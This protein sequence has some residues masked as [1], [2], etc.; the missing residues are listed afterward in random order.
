MHVDMHH[1]NSCRYKLSPPAIVQLCILMNE[2]SCLYLIHQSAACLL[3]TFMCSAT[4]HLNPAHCKC[5]HCMCLQC[6][7]R[8]SFVLDGFHVSSTMLGCSVSTACMCRC[9]ARS[10][11]S[12]SVHSGSVHVLHEYFCPNPKLIRSWCRKWASAV[13]T[14]TQPPS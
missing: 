13:I 11:V 9:T 7:K 2:P 4:L 5:P 14:H 10:V 12:A 1:C 8:F 3:I 6:Q